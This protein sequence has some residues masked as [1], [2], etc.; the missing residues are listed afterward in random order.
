MNKKTFWI[1][2]FI[3]TLISTGLVTNSLAG[4]L[5]PKRERIK[6]QSE[7]GARGKRKARKKRKRRKGTKSKFSSK[8]FK[9]EKR[10]K[11]R[12][13]PITLKEL[14]SVIK[15]SRGKK[16]GPTS[17]ITVGG[18][19]SGAR[20]KKKG[21]RVEVRKYLRDLNKLERQLNAMGQSVRDGRKGK[22]DK[23]VVLARYNNDYKGFKRR[24]QKKAKKL[25]KA[26]G[27]KWFQR[28]AFSKVKFK[29]GKKPK[30]LKRPKRFKRY[31]SFKKK[32]KGK[33]RKKAKR[34]S[35]G[36]A[37]GD[38]TSYTKKKY[39]RHVWGSTDSLGSGIEY[40]MKLHAE[41]TKIEASTSGGVYA[42]IFSTK[43]PIFAGTL[44][45]SSDSTAANGQGEAGM[46][47]AVKIINIETTVWSGY[48]VP[49]IAAAKT[50]SYRDEVSMTHIFPPAPYWPFPT[51]VK[52]GVAFEA[53]ATLTASI[54]PTRAST[55]LIFYVKGDFYA[56][57][58]PTIYVAT[59][60][61]KCDVVFLDGQLE[62]T[63]ETALRGD[64]KGIYLE[65][66][67]YGQATVSTL[68]GKLS[69][70]AEVGWCPICDE[71]SMELWALDSGLG[72]EWMLYEYYTSKLY[73]LTGKSTVDKVED[74]KGFKIEVKKAPTPEEQAKM[75]PKPDETK[76]NVKVLGRDAT[77]TTTSGTSNSVGAG[78]KPIEPKKND[79][80]DDENEAGTGGDD[81]ADEGE[82]DDDDEV[83]DENDG[84][85]DTDDGTAGKPSSPKAPKNEPT[86]KEEATR[87]IAEQKNDEDGGKQ[88]KDRRAKEPKKR[89][90][91]EAVEGDTD[92]SHS[93][94]ST[95]EKETKT[96]TAKE[97]RR[98]KRLEKKEARQKK[99][100]ER[101]EARQKK[102]RERKDAR[103]KRLGKKGGK[104]AKK[105]QKRER[106]EATEGDTG[107]SNSGNSAGDKKTKALTAKEKRRQKR[108]EKKKA[109]AQKAKEKKEAR[110][111]SARERK[112]ARQKK[113]KPKKS[114]QGLKKK[115]PK[116]SKQGLKK[117]K[118]KKKKPKKGLKKKKKKTKSRF[119][120][121]IEASK[122]RSEQRRASKS[123]STGS[124]R[125]AKK[126]KK[127]RRFGLDRP[128][129]RK[130]KSDTGDTDAAGE[131]SSTKSVKKKP[132]KT[133]VKKPKKKQKKGIGSAVQRAAEKRKA[134][135]SKKTTADQEDET[136][137]ATTSSTKKK[138][139]KKV[140]KPKKK[141]KKPKKRVKKT[142]KRVK[143]TK[144]TK[145]TKKASGEEGGD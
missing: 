28:P 118:K 52:I 37:G 35:R 56:R 89:E 95:G 82:F 112:E 109:R 98:Q 140:R 99:L 83:V 86:S 102:L 114:K 36:R 40:E 31:K 15:G 128:S 54:I 69:L 130:K 22:S 77:R 106:K 12:F 70:F 34:G 119:Q 142:K 131:S 74:S 91:K 143:K 20:G 68:K 125:K 29:K 27:F 72:K 59:G 11:R 139:K 18:S 80:D 94:G 127:K 116:K 88:V 1:G 19:K 138:P 121:M 49:Q 79:E 115:K 2:V 84:S 144:K 136:D 26:T 93:G 76:K 61:L 135:K 141:R 7:S 50:V 132:R 100:R 16:L 53:G 96:L 62:F 14:N 129:R 103:Q 64:S 92:G 134:R 45:Y 42:Y 122:K 111:K 105:T 24:W 4:D 81:D 97:K 71:Y 145:K 23:P 43:Y 63:A 87:E 85:A 90:R 65:S 39:N 32:F 110:Q 51:E 124:E 25:K 48:K 21:K 55:S 3:F 120:K 9:V 108:L 33:G 47:L 137:S 117:K 5:F 8:K 60:G 123:K 107:G 75:E 38:G 13:R 30:W 133:R 58:G 78:S 66:G 101:K 73:L 46:S 6:P 41:A 126:S 67:V 44:K 17:K 104:Q 57:G 113:K 10:N